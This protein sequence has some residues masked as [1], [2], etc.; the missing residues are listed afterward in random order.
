MQRLYKK[1]ESRASGNFQ[2]IVLVLKN[3]RGLSRRGFRL[4]DIQS[5]VRRIPKD[6]SD[7][8]YELLKSIKEG[9]PEE[10]RRSVRLLQLVCFG[11]ESLTL[12]LLRDALAID[13]RV[14]YDSLAE[15]RSDCGVTD[16]VGQMRCRLIDLS[17]GLAELREHAGQMVVQFN[18]QT[19]YDFLGDKGFQIIEPSRLDMSSL[20]RAHHEL[21]RC[22]ILY[23]ATKEILW[24]AGRDIPSLD[25]FL[26]GRTDL[27]D[28][29]SED[30]QVEFNEIEI[31]SGTEHS[32]STVEESE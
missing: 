11:F 4:Q 2:W 18:H 5:E 13:L 15:Y 12:I 28:D 30:M 14:Y 19:V 23:F 1:T 25:G 6:I 9:P 8:Y 31:K 32:V 26:E 7:L 16:T 3:V 22:C 20:S 21:A 24:A 29:A 27:V 17:R 10:R